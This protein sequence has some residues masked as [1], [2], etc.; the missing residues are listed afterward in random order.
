M[1]RAGKPKA[2]TDRRDLAMLLL[3][4]PELKRESSAVR[5]R[6]I[7]ADADETIL[8]SWREI[9]AEE[10]KPTEDDDEF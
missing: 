7:A 6:L 3:K 5:E 1:I 2:F 9:V 8:K 4:F 10:I